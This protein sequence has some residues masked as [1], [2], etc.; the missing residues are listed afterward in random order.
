MNKVI[1]IVIGVVVIAGA[2]FAFKSFYN[3]AVS[4]EPTPTTTPQAP[5][6]Q[7]TPTPTSTPTPKSTN[8]QTTNYFIKCPRQN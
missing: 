5:P 6:A 4:P 8:H 3:P 2:I 1:I 7:V